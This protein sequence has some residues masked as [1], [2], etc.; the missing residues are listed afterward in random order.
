MKGSVAL[1]TGGSGFVGGHLAERLV[2]EGWR[3][4]VLDPREPHLDSH[5]D[6]VEGDVRDASAVL[7]ASRDTG[8]IY[9]LGTVV[10]VERILDD[11]V[12]AIDVTVNGTLNALDA[13][14][15]N[16]ASLIH[17]SSSEVLGSNPALPWS[18]DSQRMIGS[19]LVDRWSYAAAKAAAEHIVLAG[20]PS[21][22]VAATVIR[23]FNVYGPRQDARFVVPILID[24]ALR[25][26]SLPVYGNGEQSRSF[27]Y[28][29]DVVDALVL[30]GHKP[31]AGPLLHVASDEVVTIAE[32]A[33]RVRRLLRNAGPVVFLDPT[34]V[35]G[36]GYE[37]IGS[38]VT[39][40]SRAQAELGWSA[41]TGLDQGL[42]LTVAWAHSRQSSD[43]LIG[44]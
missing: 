44:E 34:A 37:D 2:G 8:V 20:A 11:P 39:D 22:S 9:H 5:V 26:A 10:G 41:V 29:D 6:W 24:A 1:I 12:S 38:R 31:G 21:R 40:S 16:G 17:L 25:G 3:V 32:L 23:P 28:V 15:A 42:A 36:T 35:L 7:T 14:A 13:A 4:R 43:A 27:T 33:E 18:E 30:A 19:A